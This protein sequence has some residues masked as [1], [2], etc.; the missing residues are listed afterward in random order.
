MLEG[1]LEPE[2]LAE[3]GFHVPADPS[4]LGQ[5]C[6]LNVHLQGHEPASISRLDVR[7]RVAPSFGLNLATDKAGVK[8]VAAFKGGA[9]DKAGLKAGDILCVDRRR[10]G[11]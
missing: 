11:P 6:E 1:R 7:A 5:R 8:V 4:L 10:E 9:S 3:Y 2:K